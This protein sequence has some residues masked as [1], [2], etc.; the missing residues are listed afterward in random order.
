[1]DKRGELTTTQIGLLIIAIVGFVIVLLFL[2]GLDFKGM[3]NE[4]VCHLSVI[5]RGTLPEAAETYLPLKCQTEKICI[6]GEGGNGCKTSFA[7]EEIAEKITLDKDNAAKAAKQ[8]DATSADAMYRCWKMMGEGKI[9]L[10]KSLSKN[11][12]VKVTDKPTC[13]ICSRIAVDM[14]SAKNEEIYGA[15]DL[16]AYLQANGPEGSAKSYL[17]IF[18]DDEV[19]SYAKIESTE[20]YET[21]DIL[22]GNDAETA[23]VFMQIKPDSYWSVASNWKDIAIGGAAGAFAIAP[24]WTMRIGKAG[25]QAARA[26]PVLAVALAAGSVGYVS[27][28]V[29]EGRMAAAA[30]CGERTV[31]PGTGTDKTS[32]VNG[33]S[34]V[35][36]IPYDARAMNT[37]CG[38][39]ESTP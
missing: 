26:Y 24:K 4:E 38:I 23:V 22:P 15:T 2:L 11:L 28:N 19:S 39:I 34:M 20:N 14:N 18:T 27:W 1:M 35:Q 17:Q 25:I 6:S 21:K 3:T 7:G 8:I 12:A 31:P 13:I 16:G 29:H 33:C 9:D 32:V 36:V 37:L 5:S 30:Y 10:F